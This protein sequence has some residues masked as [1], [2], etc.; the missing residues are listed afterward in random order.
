MGLFNDIKTGISNLFNVNNYS[1]LSYAHILKDIQNFKRSGTNSGSEFNYFDTTSHKYFKILFYFGKD[2]L[3]DNKDNGSF[4]SGGLLTPT[5][6]EFIKK[7]KNT[8][9]DIVNDTVSLDAN[10]LYDMYEEDGYVYDELKLN[11]IYNHNSAWAYLMLNDEKQRAKYLEQFVNLLSNINSESPWYFNSIEGL[12][13]ALDR[14]QITDGKFEFNENKKITIKCLPDAFDNRLTS[15]LELYRSIVWSWNMKKEILPSNLRKFDM[16]IYIFESPM[17]KWHEEW[18]DSLN[19]TINID[20][21]SGYQPSYKML[22]FH[23]C[24]FDYN[25]IKSG[26][27]TVNNNAGFSTEYSID[28][29]YDDCYEL[30]YNEFI[31]KELGDVI[32]SDFID[33]SKFS[34]SESSFYL[35]TGTEH[36]ERIKKINKLTAGLNKRMNP[37]DKG[38]IGNALNQV[39]GAGV[40]YIEDKLERA[41]L[42]NLHTYSLTQIGSQVKDLMDGNVIKTVQAAQDYIDEAKKR[43]EKKSSP[44]NNISTSNKYGRPVEFEDNEDNNPTGNLSVSKTQTRPE[45]FEDNEDNNPKGNLFSNEVP[46]KKKPSGNIT[47]QQLAALKV[48]G[49]PTGKIFDN[50]TLINNI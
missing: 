15:L 41:L 32:L 47:A 40:N 6:N 10:R 39:I 27:G 3:S 5:W 2:A 30:S 22:E 36:T 33:T 29:S 23:N 9:G 18:N 44:N 42:G 37:Y 26:F 8:W 31:M 7:S 46:V 21:K 25:S 17:V 48:K 34:A 14:K 19:D 4:S 45:E 49:K 35:E 1:L 16:A 28:I 24:E 20:S 11:E 13:E 50:I 38:F 12:T 43:K